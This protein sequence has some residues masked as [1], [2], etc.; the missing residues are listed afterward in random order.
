MSTDRAGV[1]P[2]LQ[3]DL[4]RNA[5]RCLDQ[6]LTA[7]PAGELLPA[8]EIGAIVRLIVQALPPGPTFR[9]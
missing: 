9:R 6:L 3:D 7:L 8:E 1:D 2:E 4:A 5:L